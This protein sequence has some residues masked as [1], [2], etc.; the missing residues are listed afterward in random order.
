[1]QN[2]NIISGIIILLVIIGAFWYVASRNDSGLEVPANSNNQ[3]NEKTKPNFVLGIV[4]RVEG[5]TIY[6]RAGSEEKTVVTDTKLVVLKQVKEAGV[7]K[8]VSAKLSDVKTSSRIV[9]YFNES[10]DLEYKAHTIQVLNI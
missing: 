10:T 6:I 4:T 2:K 8:N 7:I 5:N 3:V 1:M 9:G